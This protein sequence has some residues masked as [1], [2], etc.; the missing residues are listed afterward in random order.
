MLDRVGAP[1]VSCSVDHLLDR[2]GA[3]LVSCSVDH[4]LD[5][6]GAPLVSCSVDHLLDGRS[7]LT[8][9]LQSR[10]PSKTIIQYFGLREMDN[11]VLLNVNCPPP[12]QDK[13]DTMM[14]LGVGPDGISICPSED[15]NEPESVSN[16]DDVM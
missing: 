10:S 16:V 9:D 13:K 1:L 11:D 12:P 6:V 5:R 4:L 8:F 15:R 14:W 7:T 2:V 3:P